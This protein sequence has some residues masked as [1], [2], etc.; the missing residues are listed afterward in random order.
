M[1]QMIKKEMEDTR[2]LLRNLPA[3]VLA[4]VVMAFVLMNLLANKSIEGLPAWLALDAGTIVSWVVFMAMDVM[5]KRFG[6]RAAT[7]V[8]FIGIGF[9]LLACALMAVAAKIP[10]VWGASFEVAESAGATVN[11]ALDSTFGGTWYVLL[12]STIAVAVSTIVNNVLNWCIGKT[13]VKHPDSFVAYACRSWVSTSAGQFVDNFVFAYIVSMHFFGWTL[14]QSIF[15]AI[16]GMVVEL[17]FEMF[18]SPFGYAILQRWEKDEV[19]K[20]YI[21]YRRAQ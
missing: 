20:G 2:V 10:G 1:V 18:F 3:S 12:G 5:V 6:P 19:G 15:C 9:N 11:G 21:E 8:S 17:L 7:K 13:F 14:K 16:T 4:F